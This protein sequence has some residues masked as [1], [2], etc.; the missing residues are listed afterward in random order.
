MRS[1]NAGEERNKIKCKGTGYSRSPLL[2]SR[3]PLS[4]APRELGAPAPLGLY[5]TDWNSFNQYFSMRFFFPSFLFCIFTLRMTLSPAS[6]QSLLEEAIRSANADKGNIQYY[7]TNSQSL[8]IAVHKGYSEMFLEHFKEVKSYD[9]SICSRAFTQGTP[10]VSGDVEL[11]PDFTPHIPVARKEN[12]RSVISIPLID[13]GRILGMIS[14]HYHL[15]RWNWDVH[16]LN[17]IIPPLISILKNFS[18]A[19][20]VN[21]P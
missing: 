4:P 2:P 20:S 10:Q 6:L 21:E 17:T 19:E 5:P 8:R 7:D 18:S 16:K 1:F 3:F 14:L 12:F 11:D 9:G 13:E 15:P